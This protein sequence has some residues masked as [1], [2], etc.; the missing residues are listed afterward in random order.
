MKEDKLI[1]QQV[2]EEQYQ[3]HSTRQSLYVELEKEV[4]LPI[5]SFLPVLDILLWLRI[6]M[7]IC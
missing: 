2:G 6:V 5:I 1:T 7:Q 3:G 4:G